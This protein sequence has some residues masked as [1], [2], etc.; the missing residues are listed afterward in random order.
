MKWTFAKTYAK[1]AP[2]EYILENDYPE[3]FAEMTDKIARE[4]IEELFTLLGH[5]NTY[6]Y[7]Y[8]SNYKYWVI[9]NI[10]N[11]AKAN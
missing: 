3:F 4:G 9:D 2:H 6:R 10:L 1:T 7:Y 8:E 11:R 5:T